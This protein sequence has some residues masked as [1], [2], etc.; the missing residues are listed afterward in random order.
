MG[1]VLQGAPCGQ[2]A[3][4]AACAES[5]GPAAV[6]AALA[7]QPRR[8]RAKCAR[9]GGTIF[10]HAARSGDS[11]LLQAL[12]EWVAARAPSPAAA[13]A[14]L[15]RLL[16]K[17]HGHLLDTPLLLA[18]RG[19]HARAARLLLAHGADPRARDRR[20]GHH[21]LH[22]ATQ[23]CSDQAVRAVLVTAP[24]FPLVRG[25][26]GRGRGRG[27]GGRGRGRGQE[28]GEDDGGGGDGGAAARPPGL[29]LLDAPDIFGLTALH[30]AACCR[31][32]AAA[33]ALIEAGAALSPR[34]HFDAAPPPGGA[35]AVRRG[36]MPLHIAAAAADLH[37]AAA[38][39]T[40][41]ARRH[42][43][44]AAGAAADPRRAADAAGRLP[45]RAAAEGATAAPAARRAALLGLLDPN[46]P[47]DEALARAHAYDPG[48][49]APP[50]PPRGL[51]SL[52]E[53][54]AAQVRAQLLEQA[55]RLAA[56]SGA[57]APGGAPPAAAVA[58]GGVAA[59][60]ERLAAAAGELLAQ[61]EGRA[62]VCLRINADVRLRLALPRH[63]GG[64]GGGAGGERWAGGALAQCARAEAP[65]AVAQR[66]MDGARLCIL[67]QGVCDPLQPAA[68]VF[69]D[70]C[71]TCYTAGAA[72]APAPAPA[73]GGASRAAAAA[74]GAPAQGCG[75]GSEGASGGA[76][77]GGGVGRGPPG[78][79]VVKSGGLEWLQLRLLGRGDPPCGPDCAE[80]EGGSLMELLQHT[81]SECAACWR[82]VLDAGNAAW[83]GGSEPDACGVCLGEPPGPLLRLLPCRHVLCCECTRVI[84]EAP[85][86]QG[87]HQDDK[88][89]TSVGRGASSVLLRARCLVCAGDAGPLAPV[90]CLI[91]LIYLSSQAAAAS[92]AAGALS[93]GAG[94]GGGGGAGLLWSDDEDFSSDDHIQAPPA[95]PSAAPAAMGGAAG[96]AREDAR[97][98]GAE[99]GGGGGRP[100]TGQQRQRQ[101]LAEVLLSLPASPGGAFRLPPL[102][103]GDKG[104]SS[105]GGGGGGDAGQE[106]RHSAAGGAGLRYETAAASPPSLEG[107]RQLSPEDG[108]LLMLARGV[109]SFEQAAEFAQTHGPHAGPLHVGMLWC[110][111]RRLLPPADGGAGAP[112]AAA[113]A[114]GGPP[115]AAALPPAAMLAL[116][117]AAVLTSQHGR[118]LPP[119][120]AAAALSCLA[121]SR[122][123]G[124]DAA[125]LQPRVLRRLKA[126]LRDAATGAAAAADPRQLGDSLIALSDLGW[127]L[128]RGQMLAVAA[129]AQAAVAAAAERPAGRSAA[130]GGCSGEEAGLLLV[131]YA[132][133]RAAALPH[134]RL[135]ADKELELA[136]ALFDALVAPLTAHGGGGG[137]APAAA[138]E[139]WQGA[140]GG[141]SGGAPPSAAQAAAALQALASLPCAPRLL[142]PPRR[143]AGLEALL[144]AVQRGMLRLGGAQLAGAAAALDELG[145]EPWPAWGRDLFAALGSGGAA[146]QLP[147]PLALAL[148]RALPRLGAPPPCGGALAA[149]LCR[150][151][152][153]RL[154]E[155]SA[156]Q[157]AAAPVAL[158]AL[159]HRPPPYWLD[160]FW[161]AAAARDWRGVPAAD[162]AGMAAAAAWLAR[163]GAARPPPAEWRAC[164]EAALLGGGRPAGRGGGR[165]RLT[166]AHR[167][168]ALAALAELTGAAGA[169]QG[170]QEAAG[171]AGEPPL[172][173]HP[174][175]REPPGPPPLAGP[176]NGA[177][178]NG[179]RVAE[180][181]GTQH[182]FA[183]GGRMAAGADG[184]R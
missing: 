72:P 15:S 41:H 35:V 160:A 146:G 124:F 32:G 86:G 100:P 109:G 178:V 104:S 108:A 59:R 36:S 101:A 7:A 102:A 14:K 2:G 106:E 120:G 16:N 93:D 163:G 52:Q 39:L 137:E 33:E 30:H 112:R 133:A 44:T 130:R 80:A 158:L 117:L 132:R 182:A 152:S 113:A 183:A 43:G 5:S 73:P 76:A 82:G 153:G 179:A 129:A 40:A 184:A 20:G 75:S 140:S 157:L 150:A 27:R 164:V 53:L 22:A 42:G 123:G 155:C 18:C 67:C 99:A 77:I 145:V 31:A 92:A 149:A 25:G 23:S 87:G 54:A 50:P 98:V 176:A 173:P 45:W 148:L 105:G 111:L 128:Q 97:Q 3:L 144:E 85:S 61:L 90:C 151:A 169:G 177:P 24:T 56:A 118:R 21:A 6:V 175:Q 70:A 29:G 180:A 78:V 143:Q 135:A 89:P 83:H 159:R 38:L 66:L 79:P 142:S 4:L 26:G 71:R 95:A 167:A 122:V 161:A 156:S 136:S 65:A 127:P 84:V 154:A 49:A 46:T 94:G 172:P 62:A 91:S 34:T 141:S 170:P 55:V 1:N 9:L 28:E 68:C 51:R 115:R 69:A 165:A 162:L 125:R 139:D 181:L 37:T 114:G 74:G 103:P 64:G 131:A 166:A 63:C 19:G 147:A 10:H 126:Q 81:Q 96:G 174:K 88:T 138:A 58:A 121:A 57:P 8:L 110:R 48:A 17:P 11:E 107:S 116:R 13:Q 60:P 12:I 119:L 47:L 168:A 171:G 134:D